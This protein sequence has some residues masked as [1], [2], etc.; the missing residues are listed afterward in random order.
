MHADRINQLLS[1]GGAHSLYSKTGTWYNH[2]RRF[3]A[4]LIDAQGYIYFATEEAYRSHQEIRI[5]EKVNIAVGIAALP[6]YQAFTIKELAH[7]AQHIARPLDQMLVPTNEATL[8]TKRELDVLVRNQQHVDAIKKLYKNTCQVCGLRLQ[9]RSGKYYSEVHHIK[10][11]GQL[12]NGPDSPDN[13]LCVCPN[14]HA[15]LDF[16]AL[17]LDLRTLKL[18]RHVIAEAC[19]AYHNQRFEQLNPAL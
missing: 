19:V 1:L 16:F 7:I 14:H 11:L 4:T 9:I 3:P 10:P 15:L 6:G 5:G 12:H 13:M 2:L 8:R 17:R 18:N